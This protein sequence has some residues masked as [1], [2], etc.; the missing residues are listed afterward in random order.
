MS[1]SSSEPGL[2]ILLL[3]LVSFP[4]AFVATWSGVCLL[5]GV[6]SGWRSLS[7]SFATEADAPPGSATA[8]RAALGLV[9]YGFSLEVG[10]AAD[11]LDLRLSPLFRVGHR[12]LRVPWDQV[13][14]EGQAFS[15]VGRMVKLRLGPDGPVLRLPED[16]WE[17]AERARR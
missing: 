3:V 6:L 1:P 7:R 13:S 16:R 4:V 2:V 15:L 5:L 9:G 12:P 8:H 17:Q 11:G 10:G 14:L